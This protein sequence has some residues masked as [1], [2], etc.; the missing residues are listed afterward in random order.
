MPKILI[1]DDSLLQRRTITAIVQDLGYDSEMAENGLIGLEK[2][3][4]QTPDCVILD[5][6]MPEMNGVQVLENLKQADIR[7][8]VIVVTA[9]IQEWIKAQCLELGAKAF[10]NKPVQQDKLAEVLRSVLHPAGATCN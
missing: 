1:V 7:V 10:L 5:M 3:K 9:D 6:L 4:T 8:P 2:I